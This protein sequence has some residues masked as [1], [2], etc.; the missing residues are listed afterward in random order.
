[1]G[2]FGNV[3]LVNGEPRLHAAVRRGEVVRFYLTNAANA[4]TFN[5]SF[6][7]RG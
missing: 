2:R 5:V 3:L 4:R 1:M 6:P 7:A